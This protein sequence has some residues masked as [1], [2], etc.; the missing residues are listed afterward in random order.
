MPWWVASLLSNVAI[1]YVEHM[2]RGATGGWISI[3]PQTAVPIIFAQW[4]LYRAFNGAPHWLMAWAV[5]A[6]GNA[7]MRLGLVA[8]I[9][10][11]VSSWPL[12]IASVAIMLGGSMLMKTA[13]K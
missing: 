13:L 6:V 3:L 5:F 7:V 12:A 9:G 8:V 10:E 4:C 1:M 11:K 2:N